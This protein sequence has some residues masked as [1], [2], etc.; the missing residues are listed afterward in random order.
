MDKDL[1]EAIGLSSLGRIRFESDHPEQEGWKFGTNRNTPK[2][3]IPQFRMVEDSH[4]GKSLDI[5]LPAGHFMDHRVNKT[6]I[7]STYIEF[8]I[9][10]ERDCVLYTELQIV[11]HNK[12]PVDNK[13]LAVRPGTDEPKAHGQGKIEWDIYVPESPMAG[14][15]IKLGVDLP[16]QVKKTF[17]RE[18]WQ[19]DHLKK[20]RIRG[21]L[22]IAE[23][24][25]HK[26]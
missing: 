17:G 3:P 15:W 12:P 4:F 8:V 24:R 5:N 22:S 16:D 18:G 25:M 7:K 6:E 10:P 21:N 23:I 2:D 9:K 19:F 13:W 26:T 14:G 1:F 11:G 20:F